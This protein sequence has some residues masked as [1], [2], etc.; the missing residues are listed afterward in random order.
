MNDME[1]RE[2]VTASSVIAGFFASTTFIATQYLT[3]E[4]KEN[5]NLWLMGAQTPKQWGA[6]FNALFE[7]VFGKE[8]LS[9][10]FFLVSAIFS[11]LWALAIW[12]MMGSQNFYADRLG[13]RPTFIYVIS[14]AIAVNI[15][16]DYVS[17]AK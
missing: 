12:L 6:N 16:A 8:I 2:L 3:K 5:L 10:R 1:V 15:I 9:L 11:L 4:K 13:F 14:G 7:A 17:I